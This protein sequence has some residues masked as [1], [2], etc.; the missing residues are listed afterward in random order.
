MINIFL[1]AS[2]PLPSRDPIYMETVD[3][4]AIRNAIKALVTEVTP[5]GNIV[6]GGHPA[7]TPL[8]AFLL[9]QMRHDYRDRI[10]LYQSRLFENELVPETGEF[11]KRKFIDVIQGNRQI[12]LDEMRR[13]MIGD[14]E[15][16]AGI[17]IGGMEGVEDEFCAF[18]NKHPNAH[19]FPIASTG[20]AANILYNEFSSELVELKEELCYPVLF[21]TLI[22]IIRRNQMSR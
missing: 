3:V 20:A 7:I 14:T 19:A 12:N 4:V 22:K 17:F 13:R 5:V 9:R 18:R 15:F 11:L 2:V 8:V 1:S 16:D 10:V 6:F 21:R